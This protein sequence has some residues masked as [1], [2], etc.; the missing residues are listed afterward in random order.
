MMNL[1]E[2]KVKPKITKGYVAYHVFPRL[3][4]DGDNILPN[5]L[6][7]EITFHFQLIISN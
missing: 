6:I 3:Q 1:D 5:S 4:Y 7:Y 2:S